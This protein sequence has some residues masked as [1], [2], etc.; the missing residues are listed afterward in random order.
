LVV[1]LASA[2]SLILAARDR[3][4]RRLTRAALLVVPLVAAL[5]CLGFYNQ[6]ASGR[7][8][9][10]S[11]GSLSVLMY[12]GPFLSRT[13]DTPA[14]RAIGA[15]LPEVPPQHLFRTTGD[16]WL[17]QYR[18]TARGGN[19]FEYGALTSRAAKEVLSAMPGEYLVRMMKGAVVMLL[20]PH[21]DLLPADWTRLP[22]NSAYETTFNEN[23]P[24]CNIQHGFGAVVKTAWCGQ[25]D[26]LWASLHF[27]P[28]WMAGLPGPLRLLGRLLTISLPYRVR[29]LVWPLYCGVVS[30]VSL[31][32]LLV[33]PATRRFAIL[34]ALP[35]VGEVTP[36]MVA[37]SGVETR[38][39]FYFHP[40]YLILVWLGLACAMQALLS[41][42]LGG[43]R[44]RDA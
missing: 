21:R 34:V 43:R 40:F 3:L 6:S 4:T 18:F 12:Y 41:V 32:Y 8:G 36:V 14:V 37:S 30:L 29:W 26:Q 24:A 11:V 39:L 10:S 2:L 13:P 35:L 5:L 1:V 20:D 38:Y 7:F 22:A 9:L 27:Q 19:I 33:R 23:L 31:G 42:S 15:L 17:T 16:L 44:G 25:Y 28:R